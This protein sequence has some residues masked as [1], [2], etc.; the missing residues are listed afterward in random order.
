MNIED[1]KKLCPKADNVIVSSDGA[2]G[3]KVGTFGGSC[4]GTVDAIKQCYRELIRNNME[5][6]DQIRRFNAAR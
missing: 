5:L 6:E 4:A 2:V 3:I 1:I